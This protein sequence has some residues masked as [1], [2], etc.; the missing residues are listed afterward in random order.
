MK[1]LPKGYPY[2]KR[3]TKGRRCYY[4]HPARPVLQ[5]AAAGPLPRWVCDLLAPIPQ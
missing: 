2:L 4:L 1:R 5:G 3:A